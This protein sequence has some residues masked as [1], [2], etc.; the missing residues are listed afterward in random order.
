MEIKA[1]SRPSTNSW[2]VHKAIGSLLFNKKSNNPSE[3]GG[4]ALVIWL[5]TSSESP[6]DPPMCL[7]VGASSGTA[8][9]NGALQYRQMV[10]F[11]SLAFLQTG[12]KFCNFSFICHQPIFE[13]LYEFLDLII[14]PKNRAKTV[15]FGK[16]M[17]SRPKFVHIYYSKQQN[18]KATISNSC[19][20][21]DKNLYG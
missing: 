12:Q 2:S 17:I 18:K 1:Q 20:I 13:F 15:G 3:G 9:F 8:L 11:E 4:D 10:A 7:V 19:H 16:K 5:I 14:I 6:N 21:V